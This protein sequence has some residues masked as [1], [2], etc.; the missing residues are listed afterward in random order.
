MTS[1]LKIPKVDSNFKQILLEFTLNYLYDQPTSIISYAADYFTELERL[2]TDKAIRESLQKINHDSTDDDDDEDDRSLCVLRK[3][4]TVV[5]SETFNPEE[6]DEGPLNYYPKTA[7]QKKMLKYELNKCF[8][9]RSVEKENLENIVDAMF[10]VKVT[11]SDMLIKQGEGGDNLY[12][13]EKG[14]FTAFLTEEDGK[15]KVLNVYENS[16]MFGE[17]ALMYNMPRACSVKAE[18]DGIVWGLDRYAFRRIVLKSAYIKRKIYEQFFEKVPMLQELNEYEK[19]NLADALIPVYFRAG[20]VII[21]E[22]DLA[23]GMYFIEEGEV[24]CTIYDNDLGKDTTVE[25]IGQGH[26]FG[27]LALVTTQPRAATVT[28]VTDVKLAFLDVEAF[29][30]LLGPCIH[31]MKRNIKTYRKQIY[32]IFG[33]KT[34]IADRLITDIESDFIVN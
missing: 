27:E 17:L 1:E 14:K 16:G 13:V 23:D 19:L 24:R 2:E 8:L 5:C 11:K 4:A 9:F 15:I 34:S 21:E 3:R 31:L 25:E 10:E 33:K 18:T 29:E 32:D 28:A 22:G 26:Y 6:E 7:D 20:E 12:V 30:R